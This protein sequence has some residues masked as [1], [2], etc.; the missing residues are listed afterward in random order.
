[1]TIDL[2]NTN[3][4]EDIN[5]D[6]LIFAVGYEA[7]ARHIAEKY[8]RNS[9]IV[10]GYVFPD[11]HILSFDDNMQFLKQVG[12]HRLE[13]GA[14]IRDRLKE[15]SSRPDF[16]KT[17]ICIDVSSLNRGAMASLLAELL[18]SEFFH[19]AEISVLYSVAVFS[20]PPHEEF[21]F[22][23]FSPLENFGG[24]TSNPERP[25]ALILGL[26][27]ET[28]H[29]VGAL[30]FLDPSVT[31]AFFPIG[32]DTQFE[33]LVGEANS[34]FFELISPDRI[35]KYPVLSPYQTFWEMRSLILSLR[36][37]ARTVLVPMGPK[38]FSSLCLVSQRMFGDEV[39]IWRA[40]GHSLATARDAKASGEITGYLIKQ[41]D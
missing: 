35:I 17:K 22:L 41:V 4:D 31:F 21:D 7:R 23:D 30:E 15:L 25:T 34:S 28:D 13:S 39:S 16:S 36:E 26:G 14:R 29:A 19:Q 1:M 37:V 33:Q 38:I 10:L 27:Y 24:W 32:S 8:Y 6:L 2:F 20:P 11:G 18:D 9:E 3:L 5:F 12:G 40:S